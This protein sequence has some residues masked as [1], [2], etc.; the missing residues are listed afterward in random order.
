MTLFHRHQ[1]CTFAMTLPIVILSAAL[2][3]DTPANPP[4]AK[5]IP[6]TTTI[7]GVTLT[8]NYA[9]L[10]QKESPAV[11]AYLAAEN[12]YTDA[13]TQHLATLQ[14]TLYKEMLG[15]IK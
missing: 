3:A 7:H 10:R 2:S 5:K 4:V 11:K 8:D 12:A 15:R 13:G 1:R 6:K 14:D 9:W